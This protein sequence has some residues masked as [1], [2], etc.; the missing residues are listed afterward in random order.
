MNDLKVL[1]EKIKPLRILIVDD[2]ELIRNGMISFMGKFFTK[3]ESAED[4]E[5]ALNKF[6]EDGSFDVILTDIRMPKMTGLELV[7]KI[8]VLDKDVFIAV[9]SGS[10]E[11]M[12]DTIGHSDIFLTKPIGLSEMVKMLEMVVIKR[13]L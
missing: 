2:E 8:R 13:G 6:Q 4:G 3:I 1:Q 10:P 11:D 7:Q 12:D 5:E 9:M